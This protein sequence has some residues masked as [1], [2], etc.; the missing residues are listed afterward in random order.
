MIINQRYANL[1]GLSNSL[2]KS[3]NFYI[4][5]LLGRGTQGNH[6]IYITTD[7]DLVLKK[8]GFNVNAVVFMRQKSP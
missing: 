6:F 1:Q 4:K 8:S 7:K 5:L 2:E 3:F